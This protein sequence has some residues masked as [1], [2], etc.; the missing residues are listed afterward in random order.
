M[1][2]LALYLKKE[3]GK[4]VFLP[5]PVEWPGRYRFLEKHRDGTGTPPTGDIDAL[6]ILDC[7][8]PDRI[9]W[10]TL[11]PDDFDSIP[12]I[13]IDHHVE[14]FPF[15]DLNWINAGASA[16][17]EM[18]YEMLTLLG[19]EITP[20]IAEA[21]YSAIITDTGR[22]T[23]ANTSARA[24]EICSNLI[25]RGGIEPSV[26]AKQLYFNFSEE[27]FRNIGIALYNSRTYC[28]AKIVFLTLDNASVRSFSTSF[29]DTEGIVDLALNLRGVELAALF[30]EIDENVTNVS[31]RSRGNIDITPV[32]AEFGGGGHRNAAGC[33]LNMPLSLA[34]NTLLERLEKLLD[35][36]KRK[37]DIDTV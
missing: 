21:L 19:A 4:R 10:G 35:K 14:G 7:S 18:V 32:A 36:T 23:F 12:R 22:F 8:T 15:G 2:A 1:L 37:V 20:P 5:A 34:Q 16:V 26:I 29:E 25:R 13:V 3:A 30:K 33:T 28:D 17:G 11:T 9:D 6:I 31:L 24:L 27:Y